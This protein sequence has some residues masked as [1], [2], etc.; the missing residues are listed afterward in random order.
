MNKQQL[1]SRREY[2][3]MVHGVTVRAIGTLTDAELAFRPQPGMR[4]PREL[5]FHIY[6]QEKT[7][8]EGAQQGQ[9][10]SE[11]AKRLNPEDE[12]AAA[13]LQGLLTVGDAVAYANACHSAAEE[14]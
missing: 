10:T 9:L 11:M 7:L 12:S 14:I 3:N 2:F 6:A 4:T 5:V 13:E 8:A 1:L